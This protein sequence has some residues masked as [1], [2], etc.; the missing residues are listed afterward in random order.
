M[1][2]P[3]WENCWATRVSGR[4]TARRSWGQLVSQRYWSY[5]QRK[6]LGRAIQ[7]TLTILQLYLKTMMFVQSGRVLELQNKDFWIWP[8]YLSWHCP[9]FR[10][11]RELLFQKLSWKVNCE[12]GS[13]EWSPETKDSTKQQVRSTT[14]GYALTVTSLMAMTST[15]TFSAKSFITT[16]IP[17]DCDG[18]LHF[19]ITATCPSDWDMWDCFPLCCCFTSTTFCLAL[20]CEGFFNDFG[21]MPN[22]FQSYLQLRCAKWRL[23]VLGTILAFAHHPDWWCQY[24]SWPTRIIHLFRGFFVVCFLVSSSRTSYTYRT[25]SH[26]HPQQSPPFTS[27]YQIARPLLVTPHEAS[28]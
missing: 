20:F 1:T 13:Q 18:R 26:P 23:D 11:I 22:S 25:L 15:C 4:K 21:S 24:R 28:S 19:T 12:F 2:L 14:Q 9:I 3:S 16:K 10:A 27:P 7:R 17:S 8:T 6:Q 5:V